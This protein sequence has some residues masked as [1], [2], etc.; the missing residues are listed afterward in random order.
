MVINFLRGSLRANRSPGAPMHTPAAY[1][2]IKCP[3][4][5][6]VTSIDVAMFD[7]MPI[8]R[9][10]VMPSAKVPSASAKSPL[11]MINSGLSEY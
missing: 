7:K 2:D 9:N 8:I 4:R 6:M 5:V 11:F 3:A 1:A 10:S